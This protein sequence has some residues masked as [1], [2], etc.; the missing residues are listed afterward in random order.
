MLLSYKPRLS[1]AQIKKLLIDAAFD[2]GMPGWD[3][4]TGQGVIN[5]A[6]AFFLARNLP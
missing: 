5:A 2:T 4:D 1:P 3:F 6:V